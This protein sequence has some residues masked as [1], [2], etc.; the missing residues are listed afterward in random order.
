MTQNKLARRL[1]CNPRRLI[2]RRDNAEEL[3]E[4]TQ[5]RDPEGRGWEYRDGKYYPIVESGNLP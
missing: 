5:K 1:G 2:D 3:V 4:W